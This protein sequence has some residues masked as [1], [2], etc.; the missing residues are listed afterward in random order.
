[1]MDIWVERLREKAD[2]VRAAG[3]QRYF[4]DTIV[5]FGLTAP[6]IRELAAEAHG[7]IKGS[8]DV[9]EAVKF[10]GLMLANRYFEV[11]A[12]GILV[13]E[14]FWKD[15]PKSLFQTIKRW[16]LAGY[17][18]NWASVDTLCPRSLGALLERYPDLVSS[19]KTW[20]KSPNRWLRRASLVSFLKLTRKPG[21]LDPVYEVSKS[22]FADADDL[23]QKANGWLLREAGKA[24][25]ARLEKFLTAN[26]P[27]IPRTTLRYA[28]ERFDAGKR[29]AILVSTRGS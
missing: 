7:M 12:V 28:I 5:C 4:K 3:A 19:I 29:Q 2:P 6:Q 21:F 10:C 24:D 23:V 26:G 14:K 1:M 25:P 20:T 9:G 11:K 22:L 13:L 27:A 15:Y 8:W 18:D 16:L 17:C